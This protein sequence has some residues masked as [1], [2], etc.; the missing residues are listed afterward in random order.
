MTLTPEQLARKR[1]K[2]LTALVWHA[3]A[4]V[5]INAFFWIV[6]LALGQPGAQWA[7]WITVFWG[8]A[9]A[10]HAL[11]YA[12]AGRQ[13]EERATQQYLNEDRG[14]RTG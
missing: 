8:F 4:F 13:L 3:G 6:D 5:I 1:A 7:F 12:V 14:H 2:D 10:F 9:L 11:T